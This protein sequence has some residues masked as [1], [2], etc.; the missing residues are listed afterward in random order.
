MQGWLAWAV[1][2]CSM[3]LIAQ[4]AAGE[5]TASASTNAPYEA[6]TAM[7]ALIAALFYLLRVYL[8]AKDKLF[9]ESL[10]ANDERHE[11]WE[12]MRHQDSDK[13]TDAL[14]ALRENCVA[15]QTRAR[16]YGQDDHR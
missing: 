6:L 9:T 4:V 7:G 1:I 16:D 12:T 3:V 13:L 8:P 14:H 10:R 15:V 11:R 5:A 2:G